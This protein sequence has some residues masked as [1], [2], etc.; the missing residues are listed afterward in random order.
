MEPGGSGS[1]FALWSSVCLC[2]TARGWIEDHCKPPVQEDPTVQT[3]RV[4]HRLCPHG[5]QSSERHPHPTP[6]TPPSRRF[7][8]WATPGLEEL[9]SDLAPSMS[10]TKDTGAATGRFIHQS[11]T[12]SLRTSGV[13]ITLQ[14]LCRILKIQLGRPRRWRSWLPFWVRV[15]LGRHECTDETV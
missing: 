9:H 2:K 8:S 11:I 10:H 14:V 6:S 1:P 12:L 7:H 4:S 13:H 3:C 15:G 5:S